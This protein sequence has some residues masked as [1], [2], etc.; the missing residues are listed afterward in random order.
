MQDSTKKILTILGITAGV[1]AVAYLLLK[2]STAAAAV[3]KGT[4]LTP[5]QIAKIKATGATT[6]KASNSTTNA[7][8]DALSK[9]LK[10]Q[11]GGGVSVGGGSGGGSGSGSTA[12]KPATKPATKP[13]TKT[14]P[15]KTQPGQP[16]STEDSSRGINSVNSDGSIDFYDGSTLLPDGTLVS[17]GGEVLQTGV[18]DYNPITGNVDYLNGW[19]LEADGILYNSDNMVVAEGVDSYNPDNSIDYSSG[20]TQ[21]SNGNFFDEN[22]N[23]IDQSGELPGDFN[24]STDPVLD[25]AVVGNDGLGGV[26]S[27]SSIDSGDP[28]AYGYDPYAYDTS[29]LTPDTQDYASQPSD[30]S[31][32]SSYDPYAY[33]YSG[34]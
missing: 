34:Y 25:S 10:P 29:S 19:T 8:T 18:Q 33:D 4:T 7:L 27:D 14:A 32:D 20:W 16:T 21:D 11:G 22:N 31:Y 28:Y 17:E 30:S 9:L 5:A 6:T 1:G 15:P 23:L 26:P 12:K 13:V 3:K 24:T 2:P